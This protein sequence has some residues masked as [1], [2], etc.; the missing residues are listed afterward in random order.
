M[1]S[2]AL[3]LLKKTTGTNRNIP[4]KKKLEIIDY[5]KANGR[6]N[7]AKNMIYQPVL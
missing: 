5:A 4:I 6:N 7:A 1:K 3:I 2:K